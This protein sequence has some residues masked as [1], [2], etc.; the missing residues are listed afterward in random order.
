MTLRRALEFSEAASVRTA[1]GPVLQVRLMVGWDRPEPTL[2]D[3]LSDCG[4][5]LVELFASL[6]GLGRDS[7]RALRYRRAGR[8]DWWTV[9]TLDQA[10]PEHTRHADKAAALAAAERDL[11]DAIARGGT[12]LPY[13][14]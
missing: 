4:V 13:G 9:R 6:A 3:H 11:L 5:G 1:E 8:T 2:L 10:D 12:Y 7:V 14:T